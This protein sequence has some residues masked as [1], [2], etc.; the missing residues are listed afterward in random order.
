VHELITN[1]YAVVRDM[2]CADLNRGQG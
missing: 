2:R 1:A